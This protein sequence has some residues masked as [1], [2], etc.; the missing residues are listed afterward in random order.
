MSDTAKFIATLQEAGD[1]SNQN[2]GPSRKLYR[3]A[4]SALTASESTVASLR[5]ER[6]TY[7]WADQKHSAQLVESTELVD[8]LR[9]E[10]ER[11][12]RALKVAV[13][14]LSLHEPGD[15]RLVSDLFVALASVVC[16]CANEKS[17][18]IIDAAR[19]LDRSPSVESGN[20]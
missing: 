9:A 1:P 13:N 15:S 11:L 2:L 8:A 5:A 10:V 17:W 16:D 4:A 3:T 20:G 19:A 18:A 12:T 7:Q 6:D 14:Q